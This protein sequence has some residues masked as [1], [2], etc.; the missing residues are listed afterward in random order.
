MNNSNANIS[1]LVSIILC[2]YNGEKYVSQQLD[3][4]VKQTYTNIEIIVVDDC[5]TDN[6]FTI[7]ND[8]K[9]QYSL[10][11]LIEND[12]NIGYI[13]NF[14]KGMS[15]AKGF[16]LSPC[17]QDDMWDLQ[18]IEKMVAEI[19]EYPL[20]YCNST[21]TNETLMPLTTMAHKKNLA[22]YNNCL[23]FA[24]DNCIAGHATLLTK[25]LF[26]K[27][28]PFP[29]NIPHD[30]WLAFVASIHKGVKYIDEPLVLYRNHST[31]VIGAITTS[32]QKKAKGYKAQKKL[33]EIEKA[34]I[35]IAA[36][37][38]FCPSSLR[39]EKEVIQQLQSSYQSFSLANNI[40]RVQ[41]YLRNRKLLLA[42]KKRP[43]WRKLIYCFKMFYQIR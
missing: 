38:N 19:N 39:H 43:A 30:W 27:A 20:I 6:T 9:K 4:L 25:D 42:I 35:R 8:Y 33:L 26:T 15:V 41:L 5:S 18:K 13:K 28:Y 36:F 34:K 2:T 17:D 32:K 7:L 21:L 29:E 12:S 37:A 14:E 40:K 11:T 1:H 24:T 16:Y 3:S 10:I 22:T 31:N 23:V